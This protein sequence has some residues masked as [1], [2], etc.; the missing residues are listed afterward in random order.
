MSPE[1]RVD[2]MFCDFSCFVVVCPLFGKILNCL[3]TQMQTQMPIEVKGL[4]RVP[5]GSHQRRVLRGDQVP[6]VA[7][8]QPR[9]EQP[10]R[11]AAAEP[12]PQGDQRRRGESTRPRLQT[13]AACCSCW[14]LPFQTH[15]LWLC[16]AGRLVA[17]AACDAAQA[18]PERRLGE[19]WL[20]RDCLRRSAEEAPA[21]ERSSGTKT[22]TTPHVWFCC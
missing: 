16:V 6:A 5:G 11:R 13:A 10:C 2:P 20:A 14:P 9:A 7:V 22:E 18:E 19:R 1:L 21:R 3:M 17:S 12:R 15:A 8:G 4:A